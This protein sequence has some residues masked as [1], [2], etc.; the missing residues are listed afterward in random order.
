MNAKLPDDLLQLLVQADGFADLQMWKRSQDLLDRIP[1]VWR[2]H[3]LV[4]RCRLSLAM[5]QAAWAAAA[6]LARTLSEREPGEVAHRVHLAYSVRRAESISAARE[7]LLQARESFPDEPILH[8]NLA[9]YECRLGNLPAAREH[10]RRARELSPPCRELALQDD[11]LESLW[12]E[13]ESEE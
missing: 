13:L 11:D 8:F 10:L 1:E 12:P 5:G 4:M 7:I 9:C 3:P 6:A 2:E